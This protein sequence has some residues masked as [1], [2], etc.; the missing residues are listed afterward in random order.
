MARKKAAR[1]PVKKSSARIKRV[2]FGYPLIIFLL[3]CSGIFLLQATFPG[4]AD[5]IHVTAKVSGPPVAQPAVIS[6]PSAGQRFSNIPINISGTCPPNAAYVEI[7]D[8]NVM[9]GAAIC[10]SQAAFS[11]RTDLFAGANDL[12]AQVFNSTD[13]EGPAGT[14]VTVYYD[15]PAAFAGI[16]PLT[17]KTDFLYKGYYPGQQ[18]NWP[19]EISGGTAPYAISVDWGDGSN[20]LISQTTAGVFQIR[21]SYA[22]QSDYQGSYV[23]KVKASDSGG[24]GAFIQFFVIVNSSPT[25]G[26]AG[27]IFSKPP[28]NL[29]SGLNWLWVVWP[30]YG[31]VLMM[32]IS[33]W[34]GEREELIILR[35]RGQLRK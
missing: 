13:N 16:A 10:D 22:K 17:L 23:I 9:R 24:Q 1:R 27:N 31:F 7:F 21:H 20:D 19:L 33:Y 34:L 32:V 4:L 2:I 15:S 35:R 6:S 29:R 28:P 25:S 3:L 11:L 14:P 30:A 12:V 18:V 26:P 5:D 8:N